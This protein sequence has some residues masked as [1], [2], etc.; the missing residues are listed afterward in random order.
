MN[1]IE[2][3]KNELQLA[4]LYNNSEYENKICES[5]IELLK[6]FQ[7]QNHSGYSASIVIDLF[8]HLARYK[9]ITP[10]NGNDDEWN[11]VEKNDNEILYQN[12]RNLNV[13][14]SSINNKPYYINSYVMKENN[15]DSYWIGKAYLKNGKY[16]NKCYIKDFKNMPTI[17]LNV[18]KIELEKNFWIM[19]V[20][21]E[22]QLNE[23]SKYYD[24]EFI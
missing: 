13:F 23:L 11:I 21:N 10:L 14:K 7:N 2:Y 18:N 16:I 3:A 1:I 6:V 17:V 8:N 15:D 12:K 9:N 19:L 20:N 4:G 22:D 5:V 24:I